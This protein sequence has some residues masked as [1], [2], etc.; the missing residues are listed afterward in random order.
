[1]KKKMFSIL[2]ISIV[3]MPTLITSV[4]SINTTIQEKNNLIT[5]ASTL[6]ESGVL[7]STTIQIITTLMKDYV[8]EMPYSSRT[9]ERF[10]RY[11]EQGMYELERQEVTSEKNLLETQRILTDSEN[12]LEGLKRHK[13]LFNINPDT[14]EIETT[15][16]SHISNLTGGNT[17]H[18]IFI[19]LV[20]FADSVKT[21]QRII[22]RK[23]YQETSLIFPA[24]GARV[25]EDNSTVFIIAFGPGMKRNWR[26]I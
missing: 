4:Q 16:P 26:L 25:I 20:P 6:P 19:K 17:T 9:K 24:I 14:V 12:L 15:I 18:E 2:L 3:L 22:I 13:F 10:I 1:M 7:E 5:Q 11:I 8:D 23:L 21:S